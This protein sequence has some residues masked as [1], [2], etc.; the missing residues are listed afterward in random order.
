M[1]WICLHRT[2]QTSLVASHSVSS[3][4]SDLQPQLLTNCGSAPSCFLCHAGRHARRSA[5][6]LSDLLRAS[7]FRDLIWPT[8]Q[9]PLSS[10]RSSH[11]LIAR[12]ASQA[13]DIDENPCRSNLVDR[14]RRHQRGL[15]SFEAKSQQTSRLQCLHLPDSPRIIDARPGLQTRV[16][17]LHFSSGDA[18][19]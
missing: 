17:C 18:S 8:G 9:A 1:K 6:R 13:C 5:L 14:T 15:R 10:K 12:T 2:S 3:V 4:A 19:K 7:S 11:L 16:Q